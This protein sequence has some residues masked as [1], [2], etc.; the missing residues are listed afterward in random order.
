MYSLLAF[1]F[2]KR[3]KK[4]NVS[5]L[6]YNRQFDGFYQTLAHLKRN[7]SVRSQGS[8]GMDGVR[9][10]GSGG[11]MGNERRPRK[12]VTTTTLLQPGQNKNG[13]IYGAKDMSLE[14]AK[15]GR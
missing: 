11:K 15:I 14:R 3:V 5:K 2:G 12:T 9:R 13:N 7:S 1:T 4:E 8:N 10:K 6:D